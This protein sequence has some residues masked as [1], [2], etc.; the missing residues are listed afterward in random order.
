[1][2][3]TGW[4]GPIK[5]TILKLQR[6]SNWQRAGYH[7][8]RTT[9]YRGITVTTYHRI[10]RTRVPGKEPLGQAGHPGWWLDLDSSCTNQPEPS[11]KVNLITDILSTL[12]WNMRSCAKRIETL[13]LEIC[14]KMFLSF[15]IW[16]KSQRNLG[17]IVLSL[18]DSKCLIWFKKK[19]TIDLIYGL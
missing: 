4:E 16:L 15:F 19:H 8:P 6:T 13:R 3:S 9:E 17:D 14:W 2:R 18:F 10:V 1:M 11:R 7:V 12:I 5:L